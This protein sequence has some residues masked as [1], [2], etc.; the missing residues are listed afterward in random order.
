MWEDVKEEGRTQHVSRCHGMTQMGID[1]DD[2]PGTDTEARQYKDIET[3][4]R[5]A[6]V[7][8]AA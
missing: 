7:A 6:A 5:I 1:S 3:G 2:F 4:S 8:E